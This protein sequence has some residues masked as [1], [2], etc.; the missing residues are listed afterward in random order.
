MNRQTNEMMT[1]A[2]P[3]VVP[4]WDDIVAW[5]KTRAIVLECLTN[6][7]LE[8]HHPPT[9]KELL[10]AVIQQQKA[11]N[12]KPLSSTSLKALQDHLDNL[13][14]SGHIFRL[15]FGQTADTENKA[16]GRRRMG[17]GGPARCFWPACVSLR[18]KEGTNDQDET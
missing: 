16:T 3:I 17:R 5:H 1:I 14:A 8:H 2:G 9:K 11:S 12:V 10:Q 7:V 6:L 15:G 4:G 18:L 13:V